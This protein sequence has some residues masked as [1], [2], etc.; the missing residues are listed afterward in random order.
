MGE[1]NN[2]YIILLRKVTSVLQASHHKDVRGRGGMVPLILSLRLWTYIISFL[3][4][5]ISQERNH[6]K[7]IGLDAGWAPGL[8]WTRWRKGSLL[9]PWAEHRSPSWVIAHWNSSNNILN[10][11]IIKLLD[12]VYWVESAIKITW[13]Y[14][15]NINLCWKFR[16]KTV[17]V[18][19]LH[20]AS[21]LRVRSSKAMVSAALLEERSVIRCN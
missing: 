12:A 11:T 5:F 14:V 8:M 20:L 13:M 19:F 6:W 2:V 16:L 21:G 3:Q 4:A 10:K 15:T 17:Y 1:T 18:G 9:L 7:S